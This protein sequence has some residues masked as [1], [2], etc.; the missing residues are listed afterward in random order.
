MQIHAFVVSY[1]YL[2]I[3]HKCVHIYLCGC[4]KIADIQCIKIVDIRKSTIQRQFKALFHQKQPP[5]IIMGD[6]PVAELVE[7]D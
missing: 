2:G 4:T 7:T 6:P 3:P 5:K 1:V